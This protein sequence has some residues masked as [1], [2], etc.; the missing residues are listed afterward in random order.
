MKKIRVGNVLMTKEEI[1]YDISQLRLGIH[2]ITNIKSTQ[3]RN[4]STISNLVYTEIARLE[5][6]LKEAEE[7]Q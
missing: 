1:Q 6:L 7:E 3:Y 2:I 4:A 5:E